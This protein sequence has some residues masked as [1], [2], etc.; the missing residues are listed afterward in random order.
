M[1]D[2]NCKLRN[3]ENMVHDY[4]KIVETFN[5]H[6]LTITKTNSINN[7]HNT[8]MHYLYQSFNCIFPSFKLMP[9]STK[10]IGKIIKSL[11]TKNSHGYH[12]ISTKMLKLS[13]PF[14]LCPLTH[15]C[16]KSFSLC[17]FLDRLKY[18]EMKPLLKKGDNLDISDY[19]PISI[20]T[21]FSNSTGKGSIHPTS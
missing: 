8:S 9:L 2:K 1:T 18:S 21:S 10:D 6:F 3:G 5:Q 14:I 13:L 20:L 7:I 11:N 16:N 19:R 15:I 17:I 4:A 12:E